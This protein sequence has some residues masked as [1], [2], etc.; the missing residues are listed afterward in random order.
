LHANFQACISVLA[1]EVVRMD[2]GKWPSSC[3]T[4]L[5]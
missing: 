1:A 3:F 2:S 5:N 4:S